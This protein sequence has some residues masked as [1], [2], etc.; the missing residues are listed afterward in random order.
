VSSRARRRDVAPAGH[1]RRPDGGRRRRIDGINLDAH[2]RRVA[3]VAP[4]CHQAR[5]TVEA[6]GAPAA[7]TNLV[8]LASGEEAQ[9][10]SLKQS[11]AARR[12]VFPDAV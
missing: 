2:R 10:S 11:A 1:R 8:L 4:A 6:A 7:T 12:P 3:G 9:V 5:P